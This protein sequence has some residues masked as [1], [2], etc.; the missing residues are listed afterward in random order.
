MKFLIYG[1]TLADVNFDKTVETIILDKDY[2]LRVYSPD[3]SL[4]VRSDEYYGHDPRMLDIGVDPVDLFSQAKPSAVNYRGR[5]LLEQSGARKF[6]LVPR[7]HR[8]GGSLLQNAVVVNS[9]SLVVLDLDREGFS[10]VF[11][12]KGQKG[13]IAAYQVTKARKARRNIHVATVQAG[14]LT[15]R[16]RSTI[17]TYNW[18]S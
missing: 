12:T 11:E 9:S 18:T 3:G 13:Y 14:G 17:Y 15:G 1:L 6:M 16:T 8:L 10:K 5:L 2:H 7:N 4:L